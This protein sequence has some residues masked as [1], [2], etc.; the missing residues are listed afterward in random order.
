MP[1]L[2]SSLLQNLSSDL[3]F[4]LR[5]LRRSPLFALTIVTTFALGIAANAAIF[6]VMDA[7][8]LRPLAVPRLDRVV[9]VAEQ[10]G[11]EFPAPVSFADYRDYAAQ[12]HAFTQLAARSQ[13]YLTLT[14][15]G[16]SEHVQATRTTLNLFTVFRIQP[17]LG[18]TFA[19]HEDQPGRD[20]EAVLTHAF[21]QTH[22]GS[23]ADAI[24]K[25]LVLDGR[26]YTVI[27]VMPQSFDHIGFTDLWLPLALSPQQ[28]SDRTRRDYTMT[29][30]LRDGV[31]VEAAAG[32]L[33]AI[34]ANLARQFPDTN[35]GWHTRVRPLA[36]TINGE[37]TPTFTRMM[38]A[39]TLLL[40]LV[41]C[42]NISNLQF[43]RTLG[44]APEL[45]VRSAL[46]SSRQ[47]LLRQLLVESLVHSTLG[48]VAGLLLA[49]AALHLIVT[50]MPSQVS[51]F[52]AGWSDIHLSVRTLAYSIGVAVVS[53]LLAGLAPA[54][55]GM[56]VDL[57]DQLKA[58][59]RSVS[60]SARS[61]RLRSLFSGAQIMLA[62]ALVA[63][64]ACIAAS[65]YTM[66][67][68]TTQFAP[69]QVLL[70]N[71]YLPSAHYPS[72]VQQ[73]AFLRD[74]LDRLR[75]LPGVRSAEFSTALPYNNTGVWWQDLTIT[76]DPA[77]PG[78]TRSTQR[79]TISPGY[80]RS[81]G[82]PLLRG[83]ALAPGDTLNTPPVAVISQRLARQYFGDRDPIG[84]TIQL[85]KA[86][87][88]T[89]P[90]TIVGIAADAIYTWVDQTP[91]PAVYLSAAQFP[92]SSGTYIVRAQGD[93]M[94]LAP[95]TRQALSAL[96]STVPVD[97]AE[98]YERFLHESLIGLW[99]VAAMLGVDAAIAL[100][101]C[102]I[103]IFAVM[104][105]LVRERTHEIGIRFAVGADRSAILLLLLRR[106]LSVT[107]LGLAA[108][109]L[110]AFGVGRVLTGIL[111]G[112]QGLQFA[113]LCATGCVVA[114]ISL[115]AG[116]L[117]ARRAASFDPVQALRTE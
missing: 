13:S 51:R 22:F 37:L 89:A 7:I 68:A 53:G 12:S 70:F 78:E 77:M 5:Q 59:S 29:G 26:P 39:A 83:R 44:R 94:A 66:L 57:L 104:A 96:D 97:P 4:A 93:P 62:T 114:L 27:G 47:R 40:M 110:L 23:R 2:V 74:S 107:A 117:P 38:L 87:G 19:A 102:A 95:S 54:V 108:G 52:L 81:L 79:L 85:G 76:G 11:A 46:G 6:S 25:P 32:E 14:Q 49:R 73:A 69:R 71:T 116:Y 84:H 33:N 90:A 111:E 65:M 17:Q 20:G 36:A 8:V 16:Q 80:L 99:Y 64:A 112:V 18:R 113:I 3:S 15:S 21:W 100:L 88:L 105:N 55:A 34:A 106:S 67:H 101:L 30:R 9:S 58:G 86:P 60:G 75:T 28:A 103:G 31:T 43:A 72:G 92:T 98:T 56:R 45:A 42:A 61:G 109:L 1:I 48:A 115:L 41:V 10:R 82:I 50:A 24:G 63:G 35:R 91:Q